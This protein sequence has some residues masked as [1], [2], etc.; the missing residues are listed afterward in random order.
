M[1]HIKLFEDFINEEFDAIESLKQYK[2]GMKLQKKDKP[3]QTFTIQM[4]VP[5]MVKGMEASG[6][7]HLKDDKTGKEIK[8]SPENYEIIKE[9]LVDSS[10][11]QGAVKEEF[12]KEL[13]KI[14]AKEIKLEDVVDADIRGNSYPKLVKFCKENNISRE[15]VISLLKYLWE[16][17]RNGVVTPKLYNDKNFMTFLTKL[18]NDHF[19]N[20]LKSY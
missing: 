7:L 16:V 8:D 2:V 1:K 17:R 5:S 4:I 6:A 3:E 9:S 18:G 20:Y 11:E 12:Y 19:Q 13:K 14:V 10:P 15:D